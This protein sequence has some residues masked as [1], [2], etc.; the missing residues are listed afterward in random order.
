MRITVSLAWW[1]WLARVAFFIAIVVISVLAFSSQ[2]PE[3]T[4]RLSDKINHALAFF[5]LALLLDQTAHRIPL[6]R[7]LILPLLGYG[8]FIE[9]VQG[10]LGYR[11]MSLLDVGADS[12]GLLLYVSLQSSF[13]RLL[14]R[15]VILKITIPDS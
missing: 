8:F 3:I 6:L 2:L 4:T 5:T 10:Q 1:R 11:E 13:R 15:L 12:V 7:G 9:L 14:D